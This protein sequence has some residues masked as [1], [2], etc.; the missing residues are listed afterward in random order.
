MVQLLLFLRAGVLSL[1]SYHRAVQALLGKLVWINDPKKTGGDVVVD[2]TFLV[3]KAKGGYRYLEEISFCAWVADNGVK[4]EE[5]GKHHVG[6]WGRTV[7][8]FVRE[9]GYDG[10]E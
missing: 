1:I 3:R 5:P 8:E 6:L 2:G 7:D 4:T 9:D 10:A